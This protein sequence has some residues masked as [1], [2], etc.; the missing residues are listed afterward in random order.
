MSTKRRLTAPERLII[1]AD[2]PLQ[3][4]EDRIVASY[5][6]LDLCHKLKNMGVYIKINSISRAYGYGLIDAIHDLGL[7]VFADLKLNDIPNTLNDDGRLL[8]E[9]RPEIVTAMC[10]TGTSA[11]R[12]LKN[13]LPNTEVIGVT[14]LTSL[15][16]IEVQNLYGCSVEEAVIRLAKIAA[17]AEIDGL[18]CAPREVA[19]LN[20]MFRGFS[21]N[22]PGIRPVWASVSGDD[23]NPERVMT[24]EQAIDAGADRIVVGRPITKSADPF[25]AV[26]RTIEEIDK[27]A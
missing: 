8:F 27:A 20:S 21:F 25:K 14:V 17:G 19:K 11:L 6:V 4:G 16:E 26:M 5:R 12:E 2:F 10:S 9:A 1:A 13:Q 15:K 24:P 7:K 18:V 3:K 23:Q 22:T